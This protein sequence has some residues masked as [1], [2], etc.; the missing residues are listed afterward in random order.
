MYPEARTLQ[1]FS[2]VPVKHKTPFVMSS[3]L[4][5][6]RDK[7]A[8]LLVEGTVPTEKE[9]DRLYAAGYQGDRVTK[10]FN[11]SRSYKTPE[12]KQ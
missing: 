8:E 6:G 1:N 3:M 4:Q 10:S 2:F 12:S 11:T 9:R 7:P 5:E